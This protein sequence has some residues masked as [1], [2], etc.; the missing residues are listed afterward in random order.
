MCHGYTRVCVQCGMC[1]KVPARPLNDPA[2]CVRCGHVNEP[3]AYVCSACDAPL[4]AAPGQS[5]LKAT[6]KGEG[7]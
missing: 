2:R 7:Q 3:G 6:R 4:V 1:G 5:C